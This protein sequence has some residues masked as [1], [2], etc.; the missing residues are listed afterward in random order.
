MQEVNSIPSLLTMPNAQPQLALKCIR[1]LLGA[2]PRRQCL[3]PDLRR[4]RRRRGRGSGCHRR[5]RCRQRTPRCSYRGDFTSIVVNQSV[6]CDGDR[7][8]VSTSG[9]LVGQKSAELLP[10]AS[11]SSHVPLG[12]TSAWSRNAFRATIC[13]GPAGF[14][15]ENVTTEH[16]RMPTPL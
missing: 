5:G 2:N 15:P 10:F 16:S 14:A 4:G 11:V 6:L 9:A 3:T 8:S 12:S 1:S 7:Q 13:I